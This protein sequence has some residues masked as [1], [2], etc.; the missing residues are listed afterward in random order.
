MPWAAAAAAIGY[1]VMSSLASSNMC[2]V[3][4]GLAGLL[5]TGRMVYWLTCRMVST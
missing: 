3:A 1:V 2:L 5:L 4:T